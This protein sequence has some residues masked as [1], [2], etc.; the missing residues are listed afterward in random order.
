M[1]QLLPVFFCMVLSL[2]PARAEAI[3]VQDVIELTRAGLGDEV[4][5]ALIDVDRTVFSIDT[6]TLTRL[7]QGGVSERVI[8]AMVRS[9][10]TAPVEDQQQ[11]VVM[12]AAPAPPVVIIEHH[13][14]V[15]DVPVPV[16]VPVYVPFVQHGFRGRAIDDGR[17]DQRHD[18]EQPGKEPVY[19]GWGGKLRP[20]AWKP[21]TP[22][23]SRPPASP[24]SPSS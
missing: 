15:R 5:L 8:L 13:E 11:S 24:R 19:W 9:G 20:D 4:L 2:A 10:R 16:A 7:K 21:A 23:S 17:F 14:T 12:E 1:R 22:P 6:A 18:R 3:T